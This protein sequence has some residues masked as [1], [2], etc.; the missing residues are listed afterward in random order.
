MGV[1]WSTAC[2][3]SQFAMYSMCQIVSLYYSVIAVNWQQLATMGIKDKVRNTRKLPVQCQT[4]AKR[5]MSCAV[6]VQF[7][8]P[9]VIGNA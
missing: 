5:K 1:A 4:V 7:R 9:N 3:T 2:P 6:L 8:C